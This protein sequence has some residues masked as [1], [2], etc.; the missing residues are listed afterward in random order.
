MNVAK[1]WALT[2]MLERTVVERAN[3]TLHRNLML[4][5]KARSRNAYTTRLACRRSQICA[6][7]IEKTKTDTLAFVLVNLTR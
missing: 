6:Y 4:K 2:M 1:N 3:V 5:V 7:E